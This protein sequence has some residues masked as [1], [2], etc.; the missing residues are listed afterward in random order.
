MTAIVFVKYV[1]SAPKPFNQLE[2]IN[3]ENRVR[4]DKMRMR[5][6]NRGLNQTDRA[7][8]GKCT[9]RY[10]MIE[11]NGKAKKYLTILKPYSSL[12]KSHA[13][14]CKMRN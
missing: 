12:R 5:S 8:D 2:S 13:I 10:P 1:P 3:N 7:R 14:V 4:E 6:R 11:L 9:D